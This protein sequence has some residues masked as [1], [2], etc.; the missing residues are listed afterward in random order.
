M[1]EGF[2]TKEEIFELY[3][4]KVFLGNRAYG[5]VAASSIYY[6]KPLKDLSIAQF[7]MIAASTQRPS[8]VNPLANK[9]RALNRRNWILKRMKDLGYIS[10]SDYQVNVSEPLTADNYGIKPEV[11]A[12]HLAEEIRKYMVSNY[13]KGVYKDGYEVYST[14][15]SKHQLSANKAL[16]TGIESSLNTSIN[17]FLSKSTSKILLLSIFLIE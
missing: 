17:K 10:E 8:E 14:I 1:L 2:L 6:G 15:N 9:R 16:K 12:G 7:A 4:N 11:E 5:V 13:G 3:V